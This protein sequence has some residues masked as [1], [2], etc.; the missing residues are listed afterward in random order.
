MPVMTEHINQGVAHVLTLAGPHLKE[1]LRYYFNK[2]EEVSSMK[3]ALLKEKI[4]ALMVVSEEAA[5]GGEGEG[6]AET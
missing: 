6:G 4:Q 2:P 5:V 1:I 3:V